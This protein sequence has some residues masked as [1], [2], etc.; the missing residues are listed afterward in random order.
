M[1]P[2]KQFWALLAAVYVVVL[3][4]YA[5]AGSW[6]LSEI[7]K[8]QTQITVLAY[9][10]GGGFALAVALAFVWA[11]LDIVLVQPLQALTRNAEVMARTDSL[12]EPKLPGH[13]F[14]GELPAT[15]R[16]LG[17]VLQ[18]TREKL[19]SVEAQLAELEKRL[20]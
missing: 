12:H 7:P 4:V 6:L 9:L 16:E 1:K 19:E 20:G 14:L 8:P 17:S 11:I 5:G 2:R 18:R 13:H 3:A 10:L 15:V